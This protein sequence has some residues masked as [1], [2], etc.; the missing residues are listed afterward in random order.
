VIEVVDGDTIHVLIDGQDYAVRYI[1]IDTPEIHHPN[2]PVEELGPEAA[3]KNAELVM[4]QTVT[5]EKDV[6]ETDD[7]GRLLRYVWVGDVMINAELVRLGYAQASTYPPDVSYQDQLIELQR[8]AREAGRGL[9]ALP[10]AEPEPVEL[11]QRSTGIE[12]D[13]GPSLVILQVDKRAEYAVIQ[14]T[15]SQP[16]DLA[17]WNLMSE[18]GSQGC[19]LSGVLQPGE[20]LDIWARAEDAGQGGFNCGYHENIWNNSE[21]DTAILFDPSG[22]V[23]CRKD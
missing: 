3:A 1:G 22:T 23:I 12:I 11:P 15:G 7:F 19:L 2:K 16:V 10:T 18:R 8:E 14:N 21:S 6:S 9:W 5:L 17:G 13:L 20:T 4:G